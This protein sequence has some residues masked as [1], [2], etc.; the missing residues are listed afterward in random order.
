MIG[1]GPTFIDTRILNAVTADKEIINGSGIKFIE[2][3]VCYIATMIIFKES[4]KVKK[5]ED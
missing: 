1:D 5:L 2:L 3:M 4:I